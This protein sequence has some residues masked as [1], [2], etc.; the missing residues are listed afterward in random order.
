MIGWPASASAS[1]AS[2]ERSQGRYAYVIG[3]YPPNRHRIESIAITTFDAQHKVVRVE[4]ATSID[5][6]TVK[7]HGKN[8]CACSGLKIAYDNQGAR[9]VVTTQ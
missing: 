4:T 9:F 5:L 6:P 3:T 8:S 2:A 7:R 1:R